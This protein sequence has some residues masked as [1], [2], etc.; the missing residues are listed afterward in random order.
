MIQFFFIL[1][2]VP[3][4]GVISASIH[5]TLTALPPLLTQNIGIP[6]SDLQVLLFAACSPPQHHRKLDHYENICF[7]YFHSMARTKQTK[8]VKPDMAIP[9]ENLLIKL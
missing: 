7:S 9:P 8:K 5:T 6:S 3:G 4:A 1:T 2:T